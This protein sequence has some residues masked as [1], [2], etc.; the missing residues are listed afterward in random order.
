MKSIGIA[1]KKTLMDIFEYMIIGAAVFGLTYVFAGQLLRVA[2]DSMVP[3]FHDGEQIVAE[4]ISLK[5]NNPKRGD[6]LVFNHPTFPGRFVIKR[7]IGLPGETIKISEGS[8]YI[9]NV[10]LQESYLDPGVKTTSGKYLE[11]NME[12]IVP[13]NSY[14]LLGDNRSNS[15]DSREWGPIKKETIEG[16]GLLVYYPF[17]KIRIIK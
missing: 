11:E 7:V 10:L 14:I 12:V 3:N 9:N 5:L 8:V 13:S 2:G 17:N 1:A 6:I 16:K 4:K 15:T